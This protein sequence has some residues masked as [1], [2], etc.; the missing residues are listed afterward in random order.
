MEKNLENLWNNN[1][2]TIITFLD[3][4]MTT[5]HYVQKSLIY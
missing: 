2:D 3:K 5:N 1:T 4:K